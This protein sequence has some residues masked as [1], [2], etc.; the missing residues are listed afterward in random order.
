M[1][2]RKVSI[3]LTLFIFGTIVRAWCDPVKSVK[4]AVIQLT[5]AKMEENK[6]ALQKM[7]EP[8]KESTEGL[9]KRPA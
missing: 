5:T 9:R 2:L 7:P 4:G 8:G 3:L 6:V 1:A